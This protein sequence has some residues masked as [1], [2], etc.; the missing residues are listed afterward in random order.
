MFSPYLLHI[1]ERP[2]RTAIVYSHT[3]KY[4]TITLYRII[5]F[6]TSSV[7]TAVKKNR[8]IEGI[9]NFRLSWLE[10]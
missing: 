8:D 1:V 4:S 3:L 2:I 6:M 5:S 10:C 7:R 9:Q